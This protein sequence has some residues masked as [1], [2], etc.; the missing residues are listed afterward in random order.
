MS[1]VALTIGSTAFG[2]WTSI[3]IV[4]SIEQIAGTFAL[5]V[6]EA[7][8]DGSAARSIV[9]GAPASV[10]IDGETVVAG[11]I[12]DL[13]LKHSATE[14]SMGVAGRDA[15]GDLVDCAAIHKSG[16]WINQ[17]MLAIASDLARPFGISVRSETDLGKPFPRWNIEPG[18][19][20]FENIDRMAR[21]RGVLVMSDGAGGI[22]LTRAGKQRAP[23]QLVLGENVLSGAANHSYR[24]RFSE[25][26]VYG[27]RPHDDDS[28]AEQLTEVEARVKDAH[29]KRYRPSIEIVEDIADTDTLRQRATWRRNVMA[30]R[31]TRATII[32]QGWTHEGGL[33]APNFRVTVSDERLRLDQQELLIVQVRYLL[34]AEGTRSELTLTIPEALTPEELP[35]R[36]ENNE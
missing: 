35:E 7:A 10:S 22:L 21:H 32:V 26:I 33:W 3:D 17:G 29:V 27:Q 18:E 4:R 5:S 6:S 11:Y 19:T 30:G 36:E 8:P 25:Y 16:Q 13:D 34:N 12:D 31:G 14:H 2:G 1:D 23:T 24:D 28:E 9:L 15:A 20:A